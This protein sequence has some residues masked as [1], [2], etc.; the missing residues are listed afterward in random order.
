M[1][2]IAIMIFLVLTQCITQPE[3]EKV[4]AVIYHMEGSQEAYGITETHDGNHYIITGWTDEGGEYYPPR[5]MLLKVDKEGNLVERKVF[6]SLEWSCD[7]IIKAPDSNYLLRSN[8]YVVLID[9]DLNIISRTYIP[10][11]T[12]N[13]VV[14]VFEEVNDRVFMVTSTDLGLPR[15]YHIYAFEQG[16]IIDSSSFYF[17]S[18]DNVVSAVVEDTPDNLYIAGKYASGDISGYKFVKLNSDLDSV[19]VNFI[20]VGEIFGYSAGYVKGIERFGDGTMAI[21]GTVV[22]GFL[23]AFGVVFKVDTNG[24]LISYHSVDYSM[25][26]FMDVTKIEGGDVVVMGS[27]LRDGIFFTFVMRLRPDLS[28]VW[29]RE[30][31]GDFD[32]YIGFG[33]IIQDSDGNLAIAGYCAGLDDMAFMKLDASTGEPIVWSER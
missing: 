13:F 14:D 32:C 2:R 28:V 3:P 15:G 11:S 10:N 31:L 21:A 33:S 18:A 9:D 1:K 24:N 8:H 12:P 17:D 27:A 19:L 30:F 4:P 5:C 22:R 26:T 25:T 16:D 23:D 29:Y 6:E 20:D 7:A